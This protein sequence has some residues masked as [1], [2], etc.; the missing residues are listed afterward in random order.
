MLRFEQQEGMRWTT[1]P[2]VSFR[3]R[4][5]VARAPAAA[6]QAPTAAMAAR[7]ASVA[8]PVV[9]PGTP[10]PMASVTHAKVEK[11]PP[12]LLHL[13]ATRMAECGDGGEDGYPM[14]LIGEERHFSPEDL[15]VLG[16]MLHAIGYAMEGEP[17]PLRKARPGE[18]R[19]RV[20]L[21]LGHAA[22]QHVVENKQPFSVIMGRWHERKGLPVMPIYDAP[23]LR[24]SRS[25][26]KRAWQDLLVMLDRLELPLPEWSQRFKKK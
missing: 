24:E 14:L 9:P 16:G 13:R 15:E 5:P 3:D 7:A 26:K 4:A 2:G 25:S 19:P 18:S 1:N 22:T 20:V 12:S 10:H 17:E 6:G 11:P 21:T 8:P 23:T